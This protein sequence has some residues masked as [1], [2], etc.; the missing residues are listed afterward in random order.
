MEQNAQLGQVCSRA[1]QYEAPPVVRCRYADT[2]TEGATAGTPLIGAPYVLDLHV[3]ELELP[4]ENTSR[5]SARKATAEQELRIE[6]EKERNARRSVESLLREKEEIIARSDALMREVD[7][8]V[9][10]SLQFV[11]SALLLQARRATNDD[12][13]QTLEEASN[14]IAA[15]AAAHQQLSRSSVSD[16]INLAD[17]LTALCRALSANKPDNVDD[18]AL[19]LAPVTVEA[20]LAMRIGALVAELVINAF[21]HA[22]AFTEHGDVRIRLDSLDHACR[23][24][25]EDD[26]RGMQEGPEGDSQK[27]FGLRLVKLIIAQLG[28]AFSC[29]LS[30]GTKFIVDIP[31]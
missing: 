20:Q 9:K 5:S 18:V 10:N 29:D 27:S 30:H 24:V 31:V 19:S 15:V 11:S 6:L 25:V 12:S 1:A 21:K 2:R 7:H 14:R 4:Q 13:R 17:F 8:R 16:R 28:G 23:L 22:Y 26:G 3:C